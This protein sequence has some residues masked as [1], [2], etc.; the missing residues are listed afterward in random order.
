MIV[1]IKSFRKETSFLVYK[2]D[3]S[4]IGATLLVQ[5]VI[6]FQQRMQHFSSVLIFYVFS[7]LSAHF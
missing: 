7:V 6:A 4:V 2:L 3:G 5:N 1:D